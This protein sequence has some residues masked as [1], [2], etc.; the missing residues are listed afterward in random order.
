MYCVPPN[1]LKG[2]DSAPRV[3]GVGVLHPAVDVGVVAALVVALRRVV[4]G[5]VEQEQVRHPVAVQVPVLLLADLEGLLPV[6]AAAD[7]PELAE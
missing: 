5:R 7:E 4:V 2:D 6:P 3:D 1:W